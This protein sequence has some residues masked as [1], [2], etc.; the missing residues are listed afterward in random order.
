MLYPGKYPVSIGLTNKVFIAQ[1]AKND[2]IQ[3][4]IIISISLTFAV[5]QFF[6]GNERN[7][8]VNKVLLI[9]KAD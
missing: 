8:I 6:Y 3:S 4:I 2:T 7:E 9:F 1:P 5:K